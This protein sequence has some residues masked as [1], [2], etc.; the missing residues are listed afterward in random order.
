VQTVYSIPRCSVPDLPP[1]FVPEI[2]TPGKDDIFMKVEDAKQ[3]ATH[4][5]AMRQWIA[6]ASG[7]LRAI[8]KHNERVLHQ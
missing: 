6:V 3:I 1:A 8:D 5:Y 7:C 2:G 4:L